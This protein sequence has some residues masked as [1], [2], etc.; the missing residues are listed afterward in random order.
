[1][2]LISNYNGLE[3][4][5]ELNSTLPFPFLVFSVAVK[6]RQ[7]V[8]CDPI[9][10]P[11][12]AQS[13]CLEWTGL[14]LVTDSDPEIF[15]VQKL[16]LEQTLIYLASLDNYPLINYLPPVTKTSCPYYLKHA[17]AHH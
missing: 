10:N 14:S 2:F 13:A 9:D 16:I 11:Y 7:K 12:I 8:Q 6:I 4:N 17:G 5:S 15:M 3:V 1:M